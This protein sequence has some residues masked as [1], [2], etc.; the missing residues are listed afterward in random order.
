ML[1]EE[2]PGCCA[3]AVAVVL[4]VGAQLLSHHVLH[5]SHFAVVDAGV[6]YRPDGTPTHDGQENRC[7]R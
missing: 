3:D 1:C 4:S 5:S 2:Y 6:H 7:A